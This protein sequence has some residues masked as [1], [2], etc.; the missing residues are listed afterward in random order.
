[1]IQPEYSYGLPI[2]VTATGLLYTG[3]AS[4]VGVIVSSHTIGTLKLWDNTAG[5]GTVLVDT[6]SFPTGSGTYWL[7]G[8]K[9]IKGIF[10]TV[11]GTLNAT[12]VYNPFIGG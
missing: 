6:F 11:S 4:A 2:A 1:M 7:Y 10:A 3:P 12:L 5:S 9:A 8:V